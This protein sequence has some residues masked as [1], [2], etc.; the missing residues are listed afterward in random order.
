MVGPV[1]KHSRGIICYRAT[2]DLHAGIARD[3]DGGG[4]R[5]PNR[6]SGDRRRQGLIAIQDEA[7]AFAAAIDDAQGRVPAFGGQIV[8]L[9]NAQIP[10]VRAGIGPVGQVD[11]P[12]HIVIYGRVLNDC[13]LLQD[14]RRGCQPADVKTIA[15]MTDEDFNALFSPMR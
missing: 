6:H 9:R 2:V 11:D 12:V 3:L 13:G 8:A 4:R 7:A 15:T 1:A 5:V 14:E 10:V